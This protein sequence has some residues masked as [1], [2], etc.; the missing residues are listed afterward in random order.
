MKDA[1]RLALILANE[2]ESAGGR[3]PEPENVIGRARVYLQFL[4]QGGSGG[5]STETAS[6]PPARPNLVAFRG[7]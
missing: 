4:Q 6:Q 5:G 7:S 1:R 2:A 3:W